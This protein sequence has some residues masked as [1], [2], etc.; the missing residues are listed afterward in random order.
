MRFLS[1]EDPVKDDD[2]ALSRARA[3]MVFLD[4]RL[5]PDWDRKI[6]LDRLD[7]G[8]PARC[9]QAQLLRRGHW[10]LIFQSLAGEVERGF[11]CGLIDL[12]FWLPIPS[13]KRSYQRLT[14]AW[15]L[16]LLERRREA[17]PQVAKAP[18][19][20]CRHAMPGAVSQAV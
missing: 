10:S 18:T 19:D 12:L 14:Q 11:A 9:I 16:L 6:D 15:K 20:D 8:S 7:V 17:E 4:R 13:V 3:G 1:F 5:G 2:V